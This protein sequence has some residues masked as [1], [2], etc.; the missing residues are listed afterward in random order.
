MLNH[1]LLLAQE[2]SAIWNLRNGILVLLIIV[3]LVAYKLYK[4]KMQG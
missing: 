1:L 3:I 2:D 4:D